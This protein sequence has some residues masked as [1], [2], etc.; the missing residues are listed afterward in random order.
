MQDRIYDHGIV[1][2]TYNISIQPSSEIDQTIFQ[3]QIK[4]SE[5]AH[6]Q[7]YIDNLSFSSE[8]DENMY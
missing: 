2:T 8:K 7:K 3:F 4:N 6:I 5:L 1:Q